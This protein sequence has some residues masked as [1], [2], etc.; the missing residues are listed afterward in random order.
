M[1]PKAVVFDLG[2]VLLDFDY[3][4][5][6]RKFAAR[7]RLTPE[8]LLGHFDYSP[9]LLRYERGQMTRVE[10]FNLVRAATGFSGD[11]AQF[12]EFFGDIF[13]PIEPMI[14]L[15]AEVRGRGLPTY[16][17]SNT[18]ELAIE[19]IRRRFPFF[20]TFVGYILSYE[21]G[22][23]KPDREMYEAVE[24]QTGCAGAEIAYLDDRPENVVAG[25]ARG[26]QAM[27]HESPEQTRLRFREMG[28]V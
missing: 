6:A 21:L 4:L 2:K 22:A 12:G 16:V 11:L 27:L 5:A 25:V 15:H 1:R 14:A 9:V 3:R 23:M 20:G 19:H 8:Q 26:W 13:T 24:R 10:F 17:F 28:L 7:S 18:N